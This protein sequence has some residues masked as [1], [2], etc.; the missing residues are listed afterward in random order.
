M[1]KWVTVQI[2]G[3][4]LFVIGIQ[5]A[6]RVLVDH[7]NRGLVS[8]IPSGFGGALTADVVLV[9]V[10]SALAWLGDVRRRETADEQ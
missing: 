7:S 2:V 6:I 10:G 3:V 8:W 5:G 1:G 4:A 9:V